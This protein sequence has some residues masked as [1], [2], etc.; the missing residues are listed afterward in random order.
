MLNRW[1][2]KPNDTNVFPPPFSVC[3]EPPTADYRGIPTYVCP[4][5]YDLFLICTKFD[6]D[7]RMPGMWLMDGMCSACGALLTVSCPADVDAMS[8]E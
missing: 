2:K 6:P 1:R 3:N 5:G 8:D 4:C 7:T